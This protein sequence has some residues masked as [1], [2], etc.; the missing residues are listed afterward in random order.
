MKESANP[1]TDQGAKAASDSKNSLPLSISLRGEELSWSPMSW[2]HEFIELFV[3]QRWQLFKNHPRGNY[4]LLRACLGTLT[5]TCLGYLALTRI[6]LPGAV[7]RSLASATT[8]TDAANPNP[9]YDSLVKLVFAFLGAVSVSYWNMGQIFNR[10]WTYCSDAFNTVLQTTDA[11][12]RDRLRLSLAIDLI[13]LDLWAHRSFR[14]L[15]RD[16][17][18]RAIVAKYRDPGVLNDTINKIS[19]KKMRED[20]A[21]RILSERRRILLAETT[22][23]GIDAD[24]A[25]KTLNPTSDAKAG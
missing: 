11:D 5:V 25:K 7:V 16:E 24:I 20:E 4:L 18:F 23:V 17:L 15:F 10:H 2:V 19:K 8:A 9:S 1:V 21:L 3:F 13:T 6:P 14:D 22:T 12:A